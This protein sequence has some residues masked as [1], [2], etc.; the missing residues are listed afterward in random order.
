MVIGSRFVRVGPDAFRLRPP[1]ELPQ[2]FA[3]MGSYVAVVIIR[4]GSIQV[5]QSLLAVPL[6]E[7]YPAQTIQ[8]GCILGSRRVRP[9][10]EPSCSRQ[11]SAVVRQRI[12]IR[13][14]RRRIGRAQSGDGLQ[15][16]P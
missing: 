8:N 15:L 12:S 14:E 6:P 2:H 16:A 4:I 3:E 5:R 7:K 13:I 10:D 9:F 11:L 1:P